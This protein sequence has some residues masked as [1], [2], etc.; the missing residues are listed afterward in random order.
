LSKI[1]G[2]IRV[3]EGP[4][5]RQNGPFLVDERALAAVGGPLSVVCAIGMIGG[6]AKRPTVVV[7]ASTLRVVVC[8]ASAVSAVHVGWLAAWR[9][10]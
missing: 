6:G 4:L 2:P 9:V 1:E 10:G 5:P 8:A 3:V 7:G